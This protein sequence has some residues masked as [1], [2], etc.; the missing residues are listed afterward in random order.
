MA[1]PR[2][3]LVYVKTLTTS[4]AQV[5]TEAQ[6]RAIVGF[7]AKVRVTPGQAPGWFDIAFTSSPDT[8]NDVTDGTGFYSLTSAG[9]GDVASVSKGL[10]ARTRSSGTVIL[11]VLTYG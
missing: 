1:I 9:M 6:A 4:W 5:L 10:W 11:E 2:L 8:S 3:G 7:K